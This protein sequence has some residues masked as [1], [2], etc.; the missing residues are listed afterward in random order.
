[1]LSPAHSATHHE[2]FRL[3]LDAESTKDGKSHSVSVFVDFTNATVVSSHGVSGSKTPV[4]S[5]DQSQLRIFMTQIA[6]PFSVKMAKVDAEDWLNN[7]K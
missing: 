7:K 4:T 3:L 6:D 1:M 2:I 5:T